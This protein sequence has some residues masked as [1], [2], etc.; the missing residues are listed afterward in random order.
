MNKRNV[1]GAALLFAILL[2]AGSERANAQSAFEKKFDSLFVIASSGAIKYQ[3]LTGPAMDSIAAMGVDVVPLLIAK[4]TTKSARERWTIIWVFQ[5]IG[6][7]AVPYLVRAL[8]QEDDLVVPRVC[9]ALG[10]IKDTAATLPLIEI[11]R[12]RNWQARDEALSALGKIGDG[13][14]ADAVVEALTDS[15]GQVRKS[16]VVSCGQLGLTQA[17]RQLVHTLNDDFYGARLT[18]VNSLLQLDTGLVFEIV[19]DSL[20]SPAAWVGHLGCRI[21]GEIGTDNA[22]QLLLQQTASTDPVRRAWA[23]EAIIRADPLD[24]CSFRQRFVPQETD[25]LVQ[26]RIQSA[27]ASN[28]HEKEQP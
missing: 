4:F 3:N 5:R 18:A 24:N 2:V 28:N 22:L 15:V 10:D 21:L 16:A 14:A 20:N 7:P 23:A 11:T 12:H 17:A 8:K 19:R 26:L 9:W 27:L 6:S 1:I 13:R 25:P